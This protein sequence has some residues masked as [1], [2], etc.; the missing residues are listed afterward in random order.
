MAY[1]GFNLKMSFNF[2]VCSYSLIFLY[3]VLKLLFTS[4]INVDT[5]SE[6]GKDEFPKFFSVLMLWGLSES[7]KNSILS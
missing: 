7:T 1:L 5:G 4:I 6:V 3:S 2:F